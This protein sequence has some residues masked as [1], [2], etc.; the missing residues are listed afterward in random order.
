METDACVEGARERRERDRILGKRKIWLRRNMM[1][2]IWEL[3]DKTLDAMMEE[4]RESMALELVETFYEEG[5]W[6]ENEDG[7][8]CF[9]TI[10]HGLY[11]S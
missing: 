9:G 7:E 2:K 3:E 4:D 11:D 1:R 10:H 6:Y 5:R 8:R